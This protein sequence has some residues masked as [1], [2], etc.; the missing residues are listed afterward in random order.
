MSMRALLVVIAITAACGDDGHA[1]IDASGEGT[2]VPD[3]GNDTR[4]V[5]AVIPA[6]PSTRS[7]A[8]RSTRPRSP[9]RCVST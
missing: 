5:L 6:T 4:E 8:P 9:I 1:P 2:V 3:D 7:G